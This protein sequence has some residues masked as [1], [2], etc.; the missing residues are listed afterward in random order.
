MSNEREYYKK[1][2]VEGLYW[3]LYPRRT[4]RKYGRSGVISLVVGVAVWLTLIALSG[5]GQTGFISGWWWKPLAIVFGGLFVLWLL[6]L[7]Y[8]FVRWVVSGF[9]D[10]G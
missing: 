3:I 9:I 2:L 5:G 1:R 6:R 10:D 4:M 8:T 7:I